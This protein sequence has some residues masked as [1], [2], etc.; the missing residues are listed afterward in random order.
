MKGKGKRP[1]VIVVAPNTSHV[2]N[3]SLEKTIPAAASIMADER[4][5]F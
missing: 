2:H 1:N 5:S 4:K 3:L